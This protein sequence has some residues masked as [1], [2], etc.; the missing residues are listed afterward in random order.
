MDWL[1]FRVVVSF[2]HFSSVM[3]LVA[4][5]AGHL[6]EPRYEEVEKLG[7]LFMPFAMQFEEAEG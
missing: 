2:V 4:L 1:T 5:V 3:L 6:V 7:H